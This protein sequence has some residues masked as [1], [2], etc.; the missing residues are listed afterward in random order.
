MGYHGAFAIRPQQ[1]DL[2]TK[3]NNQ[4]ALDARQSLVG[5]L[6]IG[7][8]AH[9]PVLYLLMTAAASI[10]AKPVC[11]FSNGQYIEEFVPSAMARRYIEPVGA[12]PRRMRW[13]LQLHSPLH[14]GQVHSSF[15]ATSRMFSPYRMNKQSPQSTPCI[16][17]NWVHHMLCSRFK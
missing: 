8:C 11:T 3:S 5:S 16:S 17:A 12:Q 14:T 13:L 9:Q 6:D 4:P 15:S 10:E 7:S 1:T 2:N